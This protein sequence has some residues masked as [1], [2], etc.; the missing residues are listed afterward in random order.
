MIAS[1]EALIELLGNESGIVHMRAL[2]IL[3]DGLIEDD[4]IYPFVRDG[5]ARWGADVAFPDFPML[6]HFPIPHDKV[7]ECIDLAQS[8]SGGKLTDKTTRCAGKLLEQVMRLPI[9]AIESHID[10]IERVASSAKIFFRVRPENAR[11]RIELKGLTLEELSGRLDS[12]IAQAVE[13]PDPTSALSD[14]F[15]ALEALRSQYPDS[16]DMGGAIQQAPEAGPAAISF[17]TAMDCLARRAEDGIEEKIAAHLHAPQESVFTRSVEAL[18]KMATPAAAARLLLAIEGAPS[19]NRTWI[20]RGLQRIRAEGLA[21]QLRNLR[22][23]ATDQK[24]WLML[25]VAELNQLDSTSLEPVSLDL[26][27]LLVRS[28]QVIDTAHVY[29]NSNVEGDKTT[30]SNALQEH[31]TRLAEQNERKGAELEAAAQRPSGEARRKLAFDVMAR[32]RKK[33]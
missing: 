10:A 5:W 16:I 33:K 3:C 11:K 23:K 32:Y 8:M 19:N 27:R 17:S 22:A 30:L 21:E 1:N 6:S 18:V 2:T 31:T 7:A 26:R 29:I 28:E 9:E 15:F 14:A 12:A 20:V 24:L 4:R 13:E 25:L